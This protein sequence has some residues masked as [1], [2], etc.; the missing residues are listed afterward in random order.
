MTDDYPRFPKI[1]FYFEFLIIFSLSILFFMFILYTYVTLTHQTKMKNIGKYGIMAFEMKSVLKS[2]PEPA[3]FRRTVMEMQ[4]QDPAILHGFILNS[5]GKIV[6]HSN[7]KEEGKFILSKKADLIKTSFPF[8]I[9][10]SPA[11]EKGSPSVPGYHLTIPF[12][13]PDTSAGSLSLVLSKKIVDKKIVLETL[14]FLSKTII[15]TIAGFTAFILI[16][17]CLTMFI[18]KKMLRQRQQYTT[19]KNTYLASIAGSLAHEI[20]NPLNSININTQLIENCLE[21]QPL[22]K[23]AQPILNRIKGEIQGLEDYLSAFLSYAKSA[24]LEKASV[25]VQDPIKA[26]LQTIEPECQEKKITVKTDLGEQPVL[27]HADSNQLQRA[28]L[29]LFLNAIH[30]IGSDGHISVTLHHEKQ[31]C[32]ITVSDTGSGIPEE[33]QN[34]IFD[35]FVSLKHEG[36]GLGLAICKKIIE[37]HNGSITF[38][39]QESGTTFRIELP[40]L[41]K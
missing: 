34:K 7:Q 39:T 11:H 19:Q 41:E 33:I 8:S 20:K 29:N 10:I 6:L 31:H 40:L 15:I 36:T 14:P 17:F 22:Y 28:L 24:P 2:S 23:Q 16:L 12:V 25:I 4:K 30:A 21:N 27:I 18:H 9:E 3:S 26:A 1:L 38:V 5:E 32:T 35:L 13:L 37:E